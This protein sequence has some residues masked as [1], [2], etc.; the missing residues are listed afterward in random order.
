MTKLHEVLAAEPNVKAKAETILKEG[1]NTFEKKQTHFTGQQRS[2]QPNDDEGERYPAENIPLVTTVHEKLNYVFNS[3]IDRIDILATKE[4]ANLEAKADVEVQGTVLIKD[5][6]ATTLL[7]LEKEIKSWRTLLIRIPTLDPLKAWS[8]D[9]ASG[10]GHWKTDPVITAKTKKVE[11]PLVLY[12]AT[13]KHPAQVKTTTKDVITGHWN[14]VYTSG[15]ITSAEKSAILGR[16][17]LLEIAIKTARQ[18]ANN[19]E[20]KSIKYGKFLKDFIFG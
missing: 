12:D 13:D 2:Y 10:K 1:I 9:E 20:T 19:V 16:L 3:L 11:Q 18:R 5:V 8:M 7:A 17:D 4:I 14:T 6:P 15:E